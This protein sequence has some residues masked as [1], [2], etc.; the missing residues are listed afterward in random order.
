MIYPHQLQGSYSQINLVWKS[1]YLLLCSRSPPNLEILS[2]G[3]SLCSRPLFL[4][5]NMK[6]CVSR[7]GLR[8]SGLHWGPS[9][10]WPSV[11][12]IT[13]DLW[14]LDRRTHSLHATQ[15]V[16]LQSDLSHENLHLL[17]NHVKREKGTVWS[18]L[19]GPIA[20]LLPSVSRGRSHD[21]HVPG[22][23]TT[24]Y[25]SQRVS[26]WVLSEESQVTVDARHSALLHVE[27]S[28]GDRQGECPSSVTSKSVHELTAKPA[29][30]FQ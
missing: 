14:D 21:H 30:A 29:A 18:G 24:A 27:F 25:T 2:A 20:F 15:C 8:V 3:R 28:I 16:S 7:L 10:T 4:F 19:G 23:R 13:W 9:I 6:S 17:A 5:C 11:P 12:A 26:D 22:N 1:S